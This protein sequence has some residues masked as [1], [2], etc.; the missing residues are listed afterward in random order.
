MRKR[1]CG[2]T[3]GAL[4]AAV[5]LL[6]PMAGGASAA[7][8]AAK[9]IDF[10][11]TVDLGDCSG[12]LVKLAGASTAGPALMLTNGHCYEGGFPKPGEVLVDK[13]S[14]LGF[15][16]LAPD[17]QKKAT[18]HAT[19][20]AYAT[21]TDTDITLYELSV[22]YDRIKY[23]YGISPLEI[24]PTPPVAGTAVKVV[25]GALKTIY[26]C[27]IDAIVHRLKEGEWITKDSIRLTSACDTVGGTSGAPIEDVATGKLIGINNTGND[28][29]ERCTEGNP[30]EIGESGEVTVRKGGKYGQQTYQL[31][32]CMKGSAINLELPGCLLPK[33]VG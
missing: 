1:A 15:S 30:C 4:L 23:R 31:A 12:S 14:T 13:P 19:K 16:L 6:A 9:K 8:G 3:L 27:D 21:M 24:S 26:S 29:G 33:P 20:V 32:G 5:T 11:G 18:L 10:S 7:T 2:T 28:N 22:S 17:G 25:A